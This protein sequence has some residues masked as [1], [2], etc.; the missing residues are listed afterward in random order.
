MASSTCLAPG[1]R[2]LKSLV[3]TPTELG[4]TIDLNGISMMSLLQLR[5]LPLW[6]RFAEPRSRAVRVMWATCHVGDKGHMV[7]V[8]DLMSCLSIF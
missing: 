1:S 2:N 4:S 3:L 8:S 7:R 6:P 5:L